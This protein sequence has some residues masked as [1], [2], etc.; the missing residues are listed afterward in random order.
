VLGVMPGEATVEA[1]P[2]EAGGVETLLTDGVGMRVDL[3]GVAGERVAV[4]GEVE[5]LALKSEEGRMVL[6][7]A[8]WVRCL[9]S[10][11]VGYEIGVSSVCRG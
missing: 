9:A 3:E 6:D 7:S 11:G 8:F 10:A 2:G 4:E 5:M 1:G